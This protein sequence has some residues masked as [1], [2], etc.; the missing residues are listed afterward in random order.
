[1]IFFKKLTIKAAKAREEIKVST[2]QWNK[3]QPSIPQ[4]NQDENDDADF[5]QFFQQL[6]S[7]TD[8]E[9]NYISEWMKSD[10]YIG[11]QIVEAW[12]GNTATENDSSEDEDDDTE[13]PVGP[14]HGEGTSMLEKFMTYF[15]KYSNTSSAELMTLKRLQDRTAKRHF[16]QKNITDI[17]QL[18]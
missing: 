15:K 5:I 18:V 16:K 2:L 14:S 7:C 10:R 8:V 4:E 11:H 6:K 13:E 12:I 17:F 9:E 1:M 3:L